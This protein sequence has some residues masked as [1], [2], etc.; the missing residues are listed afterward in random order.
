MKKKLPKIEK[1]V[2]LSKYTTFHIGGK[3]DFF[4]IAKNKEELNSGILWAKKKKLPFFVLGNGSNLLVSD[5]GFRGLVIKV[6]NIK[7]NLQDEK[8]IAGAGIKLGDLL[9]IATK[10]NLSG[11][12]WTV[13][14][15]GTIGGAVYGNAGS[16]DGSMKKSIESVEVLDI[17]KN[18]II[19][20][21][22]K[23]CKFGY[24]ESVFKNKKN[25]IILSAK[26]KL[27][28]KDK[29]EIKEKIK[30]YLFYKKERQP[31][32]FFSAGSVF[33]N[34]KESGFS[35][36]ELIAKAGLKGK[37]IGGAEISKIHANFIVNFKNAKSKDVIRLINL[38]KKQVKNK[39]VIKL[40]E[41]IQYLGKFN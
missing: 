34:P 38:I 39:F 40:K 41:E 5:K 30:K 8:I 36:G 28:K 31:L 3:A 19:N 11:L 27:E 7:H 4:L 26:L 18:K 17:K 21:K 29:E 9:K 22:N 25:L 1:N 15:P 35:A 37:R 16:F 24:R 12:E 23:D 2:F 6:Q 14:I 10:K 33:K 20:F 13:G 32:R